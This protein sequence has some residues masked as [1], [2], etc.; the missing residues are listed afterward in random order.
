MAWVGKEKSEN[1][2]I[3]FKQADFAGEQDSLK[4]SQELEIA[5]GIDGKVSADQFT[6]E[7]VRGRSRE[8]AILREDVDWWPWMGPLTMFFRRRRNQASIKSAWSGARAEGGAGFGE[9][10]SG[11]LLGSSQDWV[12][13]V[14]RKCSNGGV[15]VEELRYKWRGSNRCRSRRDR[16]LL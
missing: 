5:S 8:R 10:S 13:T 16:R 15:A 4:P 12:Q 2:R 6:E 1:A 14:A 9:R 3:G 11:I 7:S